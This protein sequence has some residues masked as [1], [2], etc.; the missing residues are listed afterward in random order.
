MVINR[1]PVRTE[2]TNHVFISSLFLF[3]VYKLYL[4]TIDCCKP[5]ERGLL[6]YR[7]HHCTPPSKSLLQNIKG[8]T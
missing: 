3:L 6:I 2:V 7:P 5:H 8:L 4:V 1:R